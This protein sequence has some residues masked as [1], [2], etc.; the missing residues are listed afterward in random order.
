MKESVKAVDP[1]D[2][3]PFPDPLSINY[4]ST[5]LS[6]I[7]PY[8]DIDQSYIE[9]FWLLMH[10]HYGLQELD[11]ILLSLNNVPYI[12]ML[13]PGDKIFLIS[14]NDL[15]NFSKQKQPGAN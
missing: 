7:P 10:N 13:S 12:G 2:G 9:H 1:V 15:V 11:D 4:N 5:Q 8:I 3:Q 6:S 14:N